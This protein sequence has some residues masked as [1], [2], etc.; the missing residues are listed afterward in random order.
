MHTGAFKVVD[1]DAASVRMKGRMNVTNAS[2]TD[3][4]VELDRSIRLVDRLNAEL[5]LGVPFPAGVHYVGYVSQNIMTNV[6]DSPLT[7]ESGTVSIWSMGQFPGRRNTIVIAPYNR[8]TKGKIVE[9]SYFGE[10]PAE[11]VVIDKSAGVVL[12]RA[13]ARL[14]SKIGIDANRTRDRIAS[15]DFD[16]NVLIITQFDLTPGKDQYVNSLWQNPQENPYAGDV[17]NS[18]N[19]HGKGG[20]YFYELES[21]SP[22]AFLQPGESI[23]HNHRTLQFHGSIEDLSKIAAGALGIPLDRVREKM[24]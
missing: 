16:N 20:E 18:Y 4:A 15:I 5:T 24:P 1:K 17:I 7:P 2:G 10:P 14:Q 11:R 12:F 22:A 23:A 3:I 19:H 6:G 9:S 21:S 13:D 8:N